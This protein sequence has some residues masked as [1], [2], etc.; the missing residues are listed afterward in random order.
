MEMISPEIT[1]RDLLAWEPRL[2][3]AVPREPVVDAPDPLDREVDW[4]LTAR[5]S[6]PML[7]MLRGGE[8]VILT[9]RMVQETGIPFVRLVHELMLQPIAG[10][11]TEA[12]VPDM[13]TT[14]FAILTLS[15]IGPETESDLNRL[16]TARN[17]DLMQTTSDVER[18][19][20]DAVQRHARPGELI[21]GLAE[22]LGVPLSVVGD[23]GA[24]LFA[25][26]AGATNIPVEQRRAPVWQSAPLKADQTLWLGPIPDDRRALTR[27]VRERIRVG[28]QRLL[29]RD[30]SAA[31]HGTA[32]S[33]A[34]HALLIPVPGT[35]RTALVDL[36]FQAGISPGRTLHVALASP[37][38]PETMARRALSPLGELQEAGIIDGAMAMIAIS[39]PSSRAFTP[40][41]GELTGWIAVSAPVAS[42]RDLPDATRQARYVAGLM[43]QGLIAPGVTMFR[44]DARLG[45]YR[46][47][48]EHW[49]SPGLE[50]FRETFLG[51]LIEADRHG[52]LLETLRIFLEEGGSLRPTAERLGIHRN[53]LTYR[54]RQLRS[55]VDV[56]LN[57]PMARLGLQMALLA[58]RLPQAPG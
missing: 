58:E 2:D 1:L 12:P 4:V 7:P 47:L 20:A 3:V 8:L 41:A 17:R 48:Y 31:P 30:A 16:L 19:I 40:V 15:Q 6:P 25:T 32:R 28:L 18:M 45:T 54:I 56:D 13:A 27:L 57:D 53:T 22:R 42:A 36:A 5:A 11:I 46:L 34:L 43:E 26:G 52:T 49:G 55:I 14:P 35:Q 51:S 21:N 44:D 23:D 10:I 33:A 38:V 9:R 37:Q 50:R 24:V 29:D 39:A